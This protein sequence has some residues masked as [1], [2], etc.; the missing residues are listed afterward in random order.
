V[1]RRLAQLLLVPLL[2]FIGLG[3]GPTALAEPGSAREYEL[4]AA[5]VYNFAKFTRWA[6]T[7]DAGVPNPLVIGVFGNPR[8]AESIAALTRG[9]TVGGSTIEVKSFG[10]NDIPPNL[11]IVY[12]GDSQDGLLRRLAPAIFQP[13]RLT[14][15]E[16]EA[17]TQNG[18]II[19]LFVETDRLR[20]EIDNGHAQKAGLTLSSQLLMLA[21]KVTTAN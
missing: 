17:F 3:A 13:G 14:I 11:H 19:R 7:G 10:P 4:K 8:I 5:Y 20:F 2:L 9:R 6:G 15:G 21:R 1:I 18:G 16:T 12:V